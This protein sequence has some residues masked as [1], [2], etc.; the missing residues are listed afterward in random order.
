M[1]TLASKRD[2]EE[3]GIEITRLQSV[4]VDEEEKNKRVKHRTW[5]N[6]T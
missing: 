6:V 5:V 1:P 3:E 4:L 2:E